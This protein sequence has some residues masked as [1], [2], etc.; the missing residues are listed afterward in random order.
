VS[1]SRTQPT[2]R[3][4][5]ERDRRRLE[6]VLPELI[7]RVLETGYEKL[8]EGPENLRQIVGDLRLPK[9]ALALILSQVDETKNG[10]Y[11]VVAREIRDFLEQTNLSEEITKALT[12][13]SFEVRTEVRFIPNEAKAGMPP[14]PNVRSSVKVK[15]Q[16]S[17]PPPSE[18]S[19]D[20]LGSIPPAAPSAPPSQPSRAPTANVGSAAPPSVPPDPDAPP[21]LADIEQDSGSGSGSPEAP[22]D[23]ID[24]VQK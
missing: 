8:S 13:L 6:R 10:L 4:D 1:N 24:E 23:N 5:K 21:E 17:C 14:K 3:D 12:A 20:S 15:R 9:E 22:I 18:S 11:R 7:R 2:E 16:S 19:E